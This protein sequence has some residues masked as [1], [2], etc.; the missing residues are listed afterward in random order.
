MT[1]VRERDVEI[2]GPRPPQRRPVQP[3]W[4]SWAAPAALVVLAG[5]A[6]WFGLRSQT[7]SMEDLA[8]AED[9]IVVTVPTTLPGFTAQELA[10]AEDR[11]TVVVP[12]VPPG[13]ITVEELV[14]WE[15]QIRVTPPAPVGITW[16]EFAAAEDGL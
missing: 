6:L 13:A 10:A 14:M 5:L 3:D 8:A 7:F 16:Q 9:Q 4:L 1:T 2:R 11:I 15:D 12:P